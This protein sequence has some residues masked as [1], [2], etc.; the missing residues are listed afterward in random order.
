MAKQFSDFQID[1]FKRIIRENSRHKG[2]KIVSPYDKPQR[3]H[4]S[5]LS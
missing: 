4:I 5:Y 1:Y 3:L 2:K